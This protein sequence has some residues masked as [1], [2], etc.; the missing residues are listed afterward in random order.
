MLALNHDRLGKRLFRTPLLAGLVLLST[1]VMGGQ[2]PSNCMF[3]I[4]GRAN[5]VVVSNG[6]VT[7]RVC[8]LLYKPLLPSNYA[9]LGPS[10]LPQSGS[11][12]LLPNGLFSF[13]NVYA[14]I[15][16]YTGAP[17]ATVWVQKGYQQDGVFIIDDNSKDHDPPSGEPFSSLDVR[18]YNVPPT[19]K[20]RFGIHVH[21]DPS[22]AQSQPG[23]LYGLAV[24]AHATNSIGAGI[25]ATGAGAIG[26]QSI[27]GDSAGHEQ[28]LTVISH[29]INH[30]TD[31]DIFNVIQQLSSMRGDVLQANMANGSGDFSGN[32]LNFL[33]HGVQ[34]FKVD[35]EGNVYVPSIKANTGTR[36]V[37]VDTTGK[38]ISQETPCSGT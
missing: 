29:Q 3:P 13:T 30:F 22:S 21:V 28:N 35:A 38:L 14:N 2:T 19:I 5:Q 20:N 12:E 17:A 15:E 27:E 36:F 33:K 6:S 18:I 11:N 24:G 8:D 32:F 16:S 25:L 9:V 4:W 31:G 10:Q 34:E 7:A 37:C 23:S 26:L 1:T